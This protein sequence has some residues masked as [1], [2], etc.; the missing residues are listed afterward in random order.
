MRYLVMFC[1]LCALGCPKP[2]EAPPEPPAADKPEADAGQP[3]KPDPP[4]KAKG[5]AKKADAGLTD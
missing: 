4:G 5:L 2:A 1:A 3:D